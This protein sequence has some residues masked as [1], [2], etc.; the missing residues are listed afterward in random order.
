VALMPQQKPVPVCL[1]M[2]LA[3]SCLLVLIAFPLPALL[4]LPLGEAQAQAEYAYYGRVPAD[5]YPNMTVGSLHLIGNHAGTRVRVYSLPDGGLLKEFTVDLMERQIVNLPNG[6]FFKVVSDRPLT[7][8]LIG[9]YWASFASTLLGANTFHPSV[10]GGYVGKEFIF[11][12]VEII[13]N[14]VRNLH[15]RVYALEDA[16]VKVFDANGTLKS[17]SLKANEFEWF[18][19]PSFGVYRITSTGYIMV[20][21]FSMDVYNGG[22]LYYPAVEGGFIG[23]RFYG[24]GHHTQYTSHL[25]WF[26]FMGAED[27][28]VTVIDLESA[29]KAADVTVEAGKVTSLTTEKLAV[30]NLAF[31]SEKP[32]TLMFQSR[33]GGVPGGTWGGGTV[34]GGV[35]YAGLKAGQTGYFRIPEV[36]AEGYIFAHKE[37]IVDVD[38]VRLRVPADGFVT[39]TGGLHKVTTD[40]NVLIQVVQ[41]RSYVEGGVTVLD[42]L[43]FGVSVPSVQSMSITYPELRLKPIASEGLPLTYIA[44]GVAAVIVIVVVALALRRRGRSGS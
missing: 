25:R 7:T 16:E 11:T 14:E 10:D 44:A 29:Q 39:L 31:E 38:D 5:L 42:Q 28:K 27:S 8:M 21:T 32:I 24:A 4:T 13:P 3:L 1:T 9:G 34:E 20:Q 26:A 15:E 33:A 41:L 37:T 18:I 23:K 6:S 40:Q 30:L 19:L 17:F 2:V 36:R 22:I 43:N 35:T 12:T